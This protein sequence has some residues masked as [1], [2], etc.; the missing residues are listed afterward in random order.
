MKDS[1][2]LLDLKRLMTCPVLFEKG[3][4]HSP[5]EETTP[6]RILRQTLSEVI[7]WR[8]R[9]CANI[10]PHTLSR[11][12]HRLCQKL[13]Q[14]DYGAHDDWTFLFEKHARMFLGSSVITKMS[15][16]LFDVEV[17]LQ[18]TKEQ[19]VS[20]KIPLVCQLR[21]RSTFVFLK[22]KPKHILTDP[23][24]LFSIV[25]SFLILD[26]FPS[27]LFLSLTKDGI[28]E[29][30]VKTTEADFNKSKKII[31]NIKERLINPQRIPSEHLCRGCLKES[32]CPMLT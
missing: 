15:N 12:I 19:G 20:L 5:A 23:E 27:M 6:D 32:E 26:E 4:D 31:R 7:R 29:T 9:R 18:L 16:P 11:Y 14:Q 10:E 3:W 25:W 24:V 13:Q 8:R 30:T 17:K 2:D 28:I 1:L 22:K 21:D